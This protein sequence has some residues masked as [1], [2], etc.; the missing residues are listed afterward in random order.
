[1]DHVTSL[2]ESGEIAGMIVGRVVVK[3]GAGVQTLSAANTFGGGVSL[4]AGG[5]VLGNDAA[6]GSG[7]LTVGG[8]GTPATSPAASLG[9][10][11]PPNAGKGRWFTCSQRPCAVCVFR[12][13]S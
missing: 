9:N 7:V 5:L 13:A 2:A 12:S 4:N 11:T 3:V 10:N 1:M 6:L 8:A